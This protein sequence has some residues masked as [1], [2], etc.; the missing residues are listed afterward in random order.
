LTGGETRRGRSGADTDRFPAGFLW[1]AATSAYQVEGATR[2]DGRGES[3]WDRF[4]HTPGR[5]AAGE[6]GDTACDHYHRWPSDVRL[7]AELGLTAYRFSIAWPRI[8]PDGTGPV[9][10]AGL[11]HYDRLVDALL[12]HGITPMVTLY[13]WDLPQPLQDRGGWRNR[14]VVERFA[15]Y[16]D[17]CFAAYG[18]RVTLWVTQ[19]EPWIVGVLGHRL[20]LH[21]PGE[22]DLAGMVR[23]MH[24]LL[25]GHGRAVQALRARG[26]DGRAGVAFSLFPHYPASEATEDV[27]AAHGS[28]GY[29][30]RWFLDPVLRGRY[31]T[32]MVRRYRTL[33]GPLDMV[34]PG[35]LDIIG[36]GA[37]FIGVNYYTPR[38]VRAAPGRPPFDWEVLPPP[39]DAPVTDLGWHIAPE[40]LTDLLLRLRADYGDLPVLVTENGA[41]FDQG[42]DA[43]GRVRDPG[44]VRFLRDHLAA[45]HAAI[46]HGVDVRGYFHWSLLDNFEWAMGYAPRFG[47]VHVDYRTQTRTIKD[48]A[49][50]YA[51]VIAANAL[52]PED[53]ETG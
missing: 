28:D 25:L 2:E 18:D 5:V 15:D 30:N 17:A 49:R 52:V 3:I 13:H 12:A 45:V 6:T 46:G 51:R 53:G 20:G 11:A 23:A 42:P 8:Q 21:A 24:H 34:R 26:R 9:N 50:Y 40:A 44:R 38:V 48:S 1:G 43:G 33:I 32:D 7:M 22:R 19:N 27:E 16:A 37:D 36:A 47:L 29:V 14:D 39:G 4:A 31:P 10:R 35:D 41:V